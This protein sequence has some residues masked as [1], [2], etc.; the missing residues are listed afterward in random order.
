MNIQPGESSAEFAARDAWLRA[1][2]VRM[3][4]LMHHFESDNFDAARYQGIAPN[5]F[6]FERHADYFGFFLKN[7]R[8][9]FQARCLLSDGQSKAL[10]DQLILFRILGHMHVR[11]P[12]Q[13]ARSVELR[14]DDP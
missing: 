5:T 4:Q 13:H 8:S 7:A 9:F 2:T 14:G 6:F 12:V 1:L 3:F 11:L 10:F